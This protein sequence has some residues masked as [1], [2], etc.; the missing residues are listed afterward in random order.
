VGAGL[1]PG[2]AA[3]AD[4]ALRRARARL[5]GAAA[6]ARTLADGVRQARARFE[7]AESRVR[8]RLLRVATGSAP[9]APFV[10]LPFGAVPRPFSAPDRALLPVALAASAL[11]GATTDVRLTKLAGAPPLAGGPPGGLGD[12][13][14]RIDALYPA[15]GGPAGAVGVQLVEA[16]DGARSWVVLVPGTQTLALG[17]ANPF[18]DASNVQAYTGLPTAAGAAVLGALRLAGVRADEPVLLA[19]HSQGGMTV[20]RLAANAAVRRRYR[21]GAVVTAGSPVGRMPAPSG[22]AVLHLEHSGD[23]ITVLDAAPPPDAADRTTVRRRT[24][25]G[26][27]AHDIRSYAGTGDLVDASAHPSLAHWRDRA[28]SILGGPGSTARSAVYVARRRP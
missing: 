10:G 22:V 23:P 16:P 17:G 12:L 28:A 6:G 24:A 21:I 5:D 11:P 9:G 3:A 14:R 20:M 27:A 19:G 15:S 8:D 7:V 1:A 26:T 25:P 18:D 2:T 13:M 4:T